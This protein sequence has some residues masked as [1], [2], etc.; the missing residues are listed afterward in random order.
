MGGEVPI[1]TSTVP[2]DPKATIDKMDVVKR[3]ALGPAEPSGQDRSVAAQADAKKR[4]A[5]ADLADQKAEERAAAGEG[6]SPNPTTPDS[7]GAI[8]IASV[9]ASG[10]SALAVNGIG[11]RAEDAG[12]SIRLVA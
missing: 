6:E 9:A 8:A 12:T 7:A 2:G 4:Q 1:D 11:L 10:L 5:Q 3:A